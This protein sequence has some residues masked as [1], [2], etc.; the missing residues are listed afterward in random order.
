LISFR[1]KLRVTAAPAAGVPSVLLP[2]AL[3]YVTTGTEPVAIL[4]VGR[5]NSNTLKCFAP[6]PCRVHFLDLL[7]VTVP[8]TDHD[9]PMS[10]RD[11]AYQRYAQALQE[12]QGTLFNLCLFWDMLFAL[13]KPILQ[14]L[15]LALQPYLY[16]ASKGHAVG[17]LVSQE[18][19]LRNSYRIQ[20]PTELALF[21]Q[22]SDHL[23]SWSQS[24]FANAFD[25]FTIANDLV[26]DKGMLELLMTAD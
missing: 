13:D 26:N 8:T 21:E 1:Q 6:Y 14:G 12:Y 3:D 19:G 22:T 2:L 25:C 9:N 23:P 7:S 10:T 16:S 4:D 17:D 24:Q 20:T 15:S 11:K 5:G 18:Q